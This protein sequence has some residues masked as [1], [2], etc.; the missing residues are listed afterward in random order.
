[1]KLLSA[2]LAYAAA[3]EQDSWNDL[4]DYVASAD[5]FP[6]QKSYTSADTAGWPSS[7]NLWGGV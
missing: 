3:M 5:E 4:V 6:T 1:M 2:F 7:T